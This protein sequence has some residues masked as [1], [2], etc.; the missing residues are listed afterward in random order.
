MYCGLC[1]LVRFQGNHNS[2]LSTLN[3]QLCLV[4]QSR[5][6]SIAANHR[7][8][9]VLVGEGR[10]HTSAL[11]ALYEA[12]HD[13]I[14]FVH[15]L[16]GARALAD[17]FKCTGSWNDVDFP[18]YSYFINAKTSKFNQFDP[19]VAGGKKT[20]Q[21]MSVSW[22]CLLKVRSNPFASSTSYSF[23]FISSFFTG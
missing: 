12:L 2:Q 4:E 5:F 10:Y 22:K 17:G 3:S 21:S 20:C 7:S 1:L 16:D 14:R 23:F 9:E 15:L 11:R 19:K 13:E 6:H 8:S 18:E